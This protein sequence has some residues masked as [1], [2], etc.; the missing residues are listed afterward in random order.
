L[1]VLREFRV[2]PH[3]LLL[4]LARER[5]D[6]V[7]V[8]MGRFRVFLLSHPDDVKDVLVVNHARFE[9]GEVLQ[10]PKR[11]LGDGLLT[12]EGELHR[13]QRRLIQPV[14]H[15]ARMSEYV[16]LMVERAARVADGW[17][18]GQVLDVPDEMVRLTMSVLAMVV[19]DADIE[20]EEARETGNALSTCLGMFGRL[21]SPYALLLDQIPSPRNREFERVLRVFDGTVA[22][23]VEARLA[24]GASGSDVLSQLMRARDPDTGEAMSARQIRDEVLTLMVAGHETWT[25]SLIWTWFLL[26]E[27]PGARELLEAELEAVLGDRPATAEDVRALRYTN[28]VYSESLRLYPP[29]WTVGRTALEDH[30]IDGSTIPAGSIV[31]LSPY[32][33]QHD[34]RWFP[35]PFAFRPERWLSRDPERLPTFALFPFGAGPRV[36]IGQPLAMLAGVL[37][38]ATIARR[39]RLELVTGHPVEPAPPLF[40]P[41]NGL[42]MIARERSR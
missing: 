4:R 24:A 21:A 2:D 25:N 6:V 5:G 27:N 34:P 1:E 36:C 16:G 40:R 28:A 30:E 22:R 12:S 18:E 35:E 15:H 29:V 9:K 23:L 38:L 20:D 39:W 31:L 14:F 41:R 26:S 11:L 8:D 13:R 33:V 32:V 37:F 3:G 42:P 17:R 10:E 19:F 7:S